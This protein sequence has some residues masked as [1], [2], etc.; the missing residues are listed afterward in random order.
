MA[1]RNDTFDLQLSAGG[2]ALVGSAVGIGIGLIIASMQF[3]SASSHEQEYKNV[4]LGMNREQVVTILRN[5][6]AFCGNDLLVGHDN[7]CVFADPWRVY[8]IKF[9]SHDNRVASKS[10]AFNKVP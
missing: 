1:S 10:F 5:G 3:M 7:S 4:E 8:R 9:D 2:V 6:K